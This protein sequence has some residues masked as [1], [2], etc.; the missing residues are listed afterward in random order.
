MMYCKYNGLCVSIV[1]KE[2]VMRKRSVMYAI[3]LVGVLLSSSCL[4]DD[5]T[6][7]IP[8]AG[9]TMINSFVGSPGVSYE[10]DGQPAQSN[11]ILLPYR[12]FDYTNLFVREGRR[13][14][15][16]ASADGAL[17]ADTVFNAQENVYYSSFIYGTSGQPRHFLTEDRIPEGTSDPAA[18]A[19]VRFYNLA[20]TPHRVTLTIGTAEQLPS[21][22]NRPTETPQSGKTGEAFIV[23]PTGTYNLTVE[24]ENGE[25]LATRSGIALVEGSYT[26]IFLT[27]DESIS[28]SYYIGALRQGVN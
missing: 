4:K 11:L 20:N 5:D 21:L 26:T 13:L 6:E 12:N 22:G 24:D 16:Y 17:L 25:A 3:A 19:G 15:V 14:Q 1:L 2:R 18:V 8:A 9:L 23:H 10:I 7:P 27:G 28:G